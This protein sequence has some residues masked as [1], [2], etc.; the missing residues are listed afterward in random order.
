MDGKW[1]QKQQKCMPT[2]KK[3]SFAA[4]P[5]KNYVG[6]PNNFSV[7]INTF[8]SLKNILMIWWSFSHHKEPAFRTFVFKCIFWVLRNHMISLHEKKIKILWKM[9][10]GSSV[11]C[12]SFCVQY[13]ILRRKPYRFLMRWVNDDRIFIV[14]WTIPLSCFTDSCIYW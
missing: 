11:V 7:K 10:L 1:Q 8:L 5:I 9:S 14:G 6:F 13:V 3:N 4:M 12:T 2:L